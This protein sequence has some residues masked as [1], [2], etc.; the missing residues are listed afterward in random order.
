MGRFI[1]G[2]RLVI[3]NLV[4]FGLLFVILLALSADADRAVQSDSV[5]VIRPQGQL[6]EQSSINP[7]QGALA[8]LS[9]DEPRQVQLRDLVGAIDAAAKD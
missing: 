3:I 1:N 4:F 6:V 2:C 7:V 9:G 8:R 5:L